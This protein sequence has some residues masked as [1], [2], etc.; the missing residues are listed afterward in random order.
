MKVLIKK[1]KIFYLKPGKNNMKKLSWIDKLLFVINSLFATI[2]LLS[3]L[4]PF[5]PPSRFSSISIMSLLVPVLILINLLFAVYWIVK[6]KRQFIL[7]I[8]VLLIGFQHVNSF[9]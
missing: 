6:L 7:S 2:L 4:L 9:Y 3:Y 5:I 1:R 8:L